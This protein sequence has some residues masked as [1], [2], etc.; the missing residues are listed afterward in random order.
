VVGAA[1][2][3]GNVFPG[4]QK[5]QT[6]APVQHF[7]QHGKEIKAVPEGRLFAE[8]SNPITEFLHDVGFANGQ[9]DVGFQPVGPVGPDVP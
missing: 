4:V 5:V 1:L 7:R 6:I 9:F 8:A 3:G 2:D